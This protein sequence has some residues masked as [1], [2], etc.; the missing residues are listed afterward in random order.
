MHQIWEPV[1]AAA[2]ETKIPVNLHANPRGGSRQ[3]GVGVSGLEPRNQSL[4]TVA[5]FPMR[6]MA[7]LMGAVVFSGIC[8]IH[9]RVRF[10]PEEAG[11]GWVP[12]LFWR[13]QREPDFGE[14]TRA[15]R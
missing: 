6:R 3:I 2:A 4:M 12:L 9:P 10:L 11:V 13:F 5:N 15:A 7:E 14:P 8:D 1:W